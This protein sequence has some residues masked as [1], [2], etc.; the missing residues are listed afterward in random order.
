MAEISVTNKTCNTDIDG[1][2]RRANRYIM[3]VAKAQSSSVSGTMSFD[4]A[5]AKS[6]ITGLR[7]YMTYITSQPI[8][9]LPET[10]PSEIDLPPKI[11]VP[12]MENDSSYD[13]CALLKL[14]VDE[15]SDSQSSRIP[16]NLLPFDKLR[17]VAIL[18][19][20]DNFIENFIK[21]VDPLDN[22]ETSPGTPSTGSGLRGG[23]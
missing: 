19:R 23:I 17:I 13:L 2:V 22:P 21:V 6:Y 15:L 16:T 9:D 3:E 12:R 14:T 1:F 7:K 10:G 4:V 5:R 11:V 8:L 18:D 20:A